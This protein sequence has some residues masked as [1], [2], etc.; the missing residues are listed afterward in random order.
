M[1]GP[2]WAMVGLPQTDGTVVILA[3][4]DLTGAQLRHEWTTPRSGLSWLADGTEIH[5]RI[6]LT[7]TM[8]MYYMAE[9]NTYPEALAR[10]LSTWKPEGARARELTSAD[11]LPHIGS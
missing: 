4:S 3:S 10:L 9:G 1:N 8:K 6:F 2:D 11:N 5:H 7:L